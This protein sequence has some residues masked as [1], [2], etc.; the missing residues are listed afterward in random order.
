[1]KRLKVTLRPHAALHVTRT[2]LNTAKMVY[3][4]VA[5]KKVRYRYGTRSQVVYI[6]TTKSGAHRIAQSAARLTDRI[7]GK[8]GIRTFDVR[9]V[10]CRPRPNVKTWV[11]LERAFLLTF[12]SDYGS[13]PEFNLQGKNMVETDEFK[14][15]SRERLREVLREIGD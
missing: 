1:M 5:S 15:F 6:G 11:K 2:T 4:I 14:Y 13:V 3:I 8:Y 10:T 7:L 12:R 9:V